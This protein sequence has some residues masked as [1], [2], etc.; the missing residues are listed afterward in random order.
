MAEKKKAS[1]GCL[2]WIIL[3]LLVLII[4]LINLKPAMEVMEKSGFFKAVEKIMPNDKSTKTALPQ[5][6][7]S[8][9][10]IADSNSTQ[11]RETPLPEATA[12][13][14]ETA[15]PTETPAA[16]ASAIPQKANLRKAAL[17]FVQVTNEA[18]L[19]LVPASRSVYFDDSPLKETLLELFKGPSKTDLNNGLIS[20]IPKNTQLLDVYVKNGIAYINL[21]DDFRFN[22]LE[23]KGH[24]A[25][26][27]QI[28]HTATEY[29][30]VKAVQ[31]LIEG[32]TLDYIGPEGVY[33]KE[34]LGRNSII[35]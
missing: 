23:R 13:P 30:T 14:T 1:I 16:K 11:E 25:Q 17:Y 33:I 31:F 19:K 6:E 12:L 18:E 21:N 15:S 10:P 5:A 24:I 22:S 3:I 28:I 32:K 26:L 27:K 7:E 2:F 35:K 29:S 9:S 4:I 20:Q 34:P 8:P